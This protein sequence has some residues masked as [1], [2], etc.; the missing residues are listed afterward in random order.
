MISRQAPKT[1][2]TQT[3]KGRRIGAFT[4]GICANWWPIYSAFPLKKAS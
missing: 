4:T 1:Q 3:L 2:R